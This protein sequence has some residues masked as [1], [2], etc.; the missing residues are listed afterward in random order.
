MKRHSKIKRRSRKIT[1]ITLIIV[2]LFT[3]I[4]SSDINY[5]ESLQNTAITNNINTIPFTPFIPNQHLDDKERFLTTISHQ[6]ANVPQPDSYEYTLL[7]AYGAVFINQEPEI[8]LPSKVIL[9]NE[10]ETQD[11]QGNLRVALVEGTIEC[12]LQKSAADA[13]NKARNLVNIPLKSG[14][15]GDCTRSFATN[16]RFWQKYA[17]SQTLSQ[18]KQGRETK[19]LDTVAPPGTSQ[20]LWGLAIDLRVSS[21]AQRQ[22]LNQNGWFQTVQN[23]IPHW[24][25]LHWSEEDLP[26][27]GLRAKTVKGIT[28]WVTPL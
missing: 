2:I 20:H 14:Y 9:E 1:F 28:Y 5:Y 11:F 7:R 17:N 19:I 15:S 4:G 18:V 23:D 25:Y 10:Q 27:F 16:L 3:I 13:F 12:Y 26:K 21:P 6:S 24:T 22:A 8:K